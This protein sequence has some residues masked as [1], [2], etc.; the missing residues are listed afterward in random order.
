[1]GIAQKLGQSDQVAEQIKTKSITFTVGE[2]SITLRV[3]V[4]V[5]REMEAMLELIANPAPARVDELYETLSKSLRESIATGGEDFL[6]TINAEREVLEV[7]D[8]DM[9]LDGTSLRSMANLTA[10]W[11][12]KVESYFHLL[13]SETGDP[14]TEKYD[15]IADEFPEQAI[16]KIVE[17]IEAVI[18]PTYKSAK[19]N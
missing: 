8:T 13:Q 14:I 2:A 19:K 7:T 6:K 15:Q 9:I 17:E 5:K 10:M 1:M 4:P 12:T 11:E 16:R 3:R 18:R